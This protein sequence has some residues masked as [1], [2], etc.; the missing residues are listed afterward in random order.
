MR[1]ARPWQATLHGTPIY[2]KVGTS[3]FHK[4]C[5][6]SDDLVVLLG[7]QFEPIVRAARGP[8]PVLCTLMLPDQLGRDATEGTSGDKV[9]LRRFKAELLI[10]LGAR[11]PVIPGFIPGL[12]VLVTSIWVGA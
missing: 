12:G 2:S 3:L 11:A 5:V 7:E 4:L 6:Q 9:K 1:L 10:Q 8:E